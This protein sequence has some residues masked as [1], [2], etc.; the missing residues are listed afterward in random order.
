VGARIRIKRKNGYKNPIALRPALP[1]YILSRPVR[2]LA[3]GAIVIGFVVVL[4][5]QV[6]EFL[7]CIPRAE[8]EPLKAAIVSEM[9]AQYDR[10][11]PVADGLALMLE[12][13]GYLITCRPLT[14][15]EK[16]L[17]EAKAGYFAMAIKVLWAGYLD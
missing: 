16:K 3:G 6:R 14:G 13:S 15:A 7:L 17:Y 1:G 8:R 12:V 10:K 5:S 11:V 9:S 2:N 4:S